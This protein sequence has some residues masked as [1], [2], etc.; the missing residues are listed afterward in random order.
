[1]FVIGLS[2]RLS[3]CLSS[4]SAMAFTLAP[5]LG[6]MEGKTP[7]KGHEMNYLLR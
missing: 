2:V 3:V 4:L 5:S 6:S 1:M 7:L